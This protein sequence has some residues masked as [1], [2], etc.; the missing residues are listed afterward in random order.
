[1]SEQLKVSAAEQPKLKLDIK[2][3]V[4]VGLAFFTVCI[5]WQVYDAL[6]PLF[7]RSF[8]QFGSKEWLIGLVMAG[9]NILALILLPLMGRVSDRTKTRFGKRIPYI[10][11]G[12]VLAASTLLLVNYA[13]EAHN[14]ALLLVSTVFL[15]IFMCLYRTPAVSLM[16]D[17]TPKQIRSKA[18]AIINIMGVVGGLIA[19]VLM[20]ENL[21]LILPE[22]IGETTYGEPI[23]MLST[24]A[25]SWVVI[26]VVAAFMIA[27]S[28][29]M[30][31]KVKENLLVEKK[32]EMLERFNIN[33][34]AEE[35]TEKIK[36]T[37]LSKPEMKSYVL[38]L[39]SVVLWFFGYNAATTWFTTFAYDRLG[40][41]G[42]SFPMII[43]SVAAFAM[44]IPSSLIG[45]KIGRRKTILI[46][47]GIMTAGLLIAALMVLFVTDANI[48][49]PMMFP[50]FAL[51]GAGWATIN[52]HS[53]V[54][55]VE[56]AKK[57]N[58][59][60]FTGLYYTCSMGAQALTPVLA[61]LFYGWD[62][63]SLFF[64]SAFF[65]AVSAATMF[66][67]KHGNAKTADNRSALEKLD[68]PD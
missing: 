22:K 20:N 3:T 27:A 63:R 33:E 1:M 15:L 54:M 51:V 50:V 25:G 68:N 43:A 47:I 40:G 35:Q 9:D 14:L 61:G 52:V 16:P 24:G 34:D 30:V 53:Y 67:V 17:V 41:T 55:A 6:M 45:N 7:L 62:Y 42:F 28:V 19:L 29:F 36:G 2:Q 32:R 26:G 57:G 13:H 39:A 56:L 18:N 4:L 49:K 12:S 59:G 8:D 31:F 10:V 60:V 65:V 48:L 5:F 44:Y 11:I 58:T 23:L 21:K 38:I 46:G 64:Y 66:F 37:G